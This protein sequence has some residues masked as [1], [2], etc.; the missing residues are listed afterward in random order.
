M[1]WDAS[2]RYIAASTVT[3]TI[4]CEYGYFPV[5][6]DGFQGMDMPLSGVCNVGPITSFGPNA[7]DAGLGGSFPSELELNLA[8]SS[9]SCDPVAN[10]QGPPQW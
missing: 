6:L 2:G 7:L 3:P 9:E 4:H 5:A 8:L 10:F 1:N